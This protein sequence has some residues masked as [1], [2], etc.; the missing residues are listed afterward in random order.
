MGDNRTSQGLSSDQKHPTSVKHQPATKTHSK[1]FLPGPPKKRESRGPT[2]E[3]LLPPTSSLALKA[4]QAK[5]SATKPP[6]SDPPETQ[7]TDVSTKVAMEISPTPN[8]EQGRAQIG[9]L[10]IKSR[11]RSAT[12]KSREKADLSLSS[13]PEPAPVAQNPRYPKRHKTRQTALANRSPAAGANNSSSFQ[14]TSPTRRRHKQIMRAKRTNGEGGE[15]LAKEDTGLGNSEK[16]GGETMEAPKG[17]SDPEVPEK[18]LFTMKGPHEPGLKHLAAAIDPL[19]QAK[20]AHNRPT[21]P[22]IEDE[23]NLSDRTIRPERR[24]SPGK[25]ITSQSGGLADEDTIS[26][27]AVSAHPSI[28]NTADQN[29]LRREESGA[30]VSGR[31][32]EYDAANLRPIMDALVSPQPVQAHYASDHPEMNTPEQ[33]LLNI[34]QNP[35]PAVIDPQLRAIPV[36]QGQRYNYYAEIQYTVYI[37][38][39]GPW[40]PSPATRWNRFNVTS[41]SLVTV[42]FEYIG[43]SRPDTG[44]VEIGGG[45]IAHYLGDVRRYGT[46][47]DQTGWPTTLCLR[48]CERLPLG[49]TRWGDFMR[50]TGMRIY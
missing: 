24:R 47:M 37:W 34:S 15:A 49:F 48:P 39:S 40:P 44:L 20:D 7:S 13:M 23:G 43:R 12:A 21:S 18:F 27:L 22:P 5:M 50:S 1:L 9:G 25:E 28:Q 16:E 4:S 41:S 46:R 33:L 26:T 11:T 19:P 3:A 29:I 32:N 8:L 45:V 14:N 10:S 42:L 35:S 30:D 6:N 31:S 38:A 17:K 2:K 36:H